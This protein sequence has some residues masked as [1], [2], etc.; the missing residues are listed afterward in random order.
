MRCW[1]SRLA[2]YGLGRGFTVDP[3]VA[4][5][6]QRWLRDCRNR[7]DE[8]GDDPCEVLKQQLVKKIGGDGLLRAG[9]G[10]PDPAIRRW[11]VYGLQ[12]GERTDDDRCRSAWAAHDIAL[13]MATPA[14]VAASFFNI[15]NLSADEVIYPCEVDGHAEPEYDFAVVDA[16]QPAT[17]VLAEGDRASQL[18]KV[19]PPALPPELRKPLA[20]WVKKVKAL[21]DACPQMYSD[22]PDG[23]NP[24]KPTRA[25]LARGQAY[26]DELKPQP[27][28]AAFVYLHLLR[29]AQ[30][31]DFMDDDLFVDFFDGHLSG[32]AVFA[33]GLR[34]V[35]DPAVM[36]QGLVAALQ[37]QAAKGDD[38]WEIGDGPGH[39][40]RLTWF[41]WRHVCG[42]AASERTDGQPC[43][44][45]WVRW[46]Q[47]HRS[48]TP[49][50]WHREG[51]LATLDA[52]QCSEHGERQY[53]A[54]ILLRSP[55]PDDRLR[56]LWTI[57]DL[58]LTTGSD[59]RDFFNTVRDLVK[60]VPIRDILFPAPVDGRRAV[61]LAAEP[62]PAHKAE[63]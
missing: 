6:V 24:A 14:S 16:S 42:P 17:P 31:P 61:N 41:T 45:A 10:N 53:A 30:A 60:D 33:G 48:Q 43:V 49:E 34:H 47:A 9:L 46:Y 15:E 37:Q 3:A 25:C 52:R 56:A 51:R 13:D 39:F 20:K 18:P 4:A 63:R 29:D 59:H 55:E 57:R 40:G 54:E 28:L 21:D 44:A 32:M 7:D 22:G 50:E 2:R 62:Q 27:V 23:D 38:D 8:T 19:L 58:L 36:V 1:R 35:A 12:Q 11:A 5:D 26:L